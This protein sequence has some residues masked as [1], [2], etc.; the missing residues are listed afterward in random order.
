[1]PRINK[2]EKAKLES[3]ARRENS[4]LVS[5]EAGL[6]ADARHF[7]RLHPEAENN[8]IAMA[9]LDY[10]DRCVGDVDEVSEQANKDGYDD[11]ERDGYKDGEADVIK[12]YLLPVLEAAETAI[13]ARENESE[14]QAEVFQG[15]QLAIEAAMKFINK[16][17]N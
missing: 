7:L 2:I 5:I 8:A 10:M 16:K 17:G 11:G 4:K 9:V 14:D 3:L 15:L 1:M 13:S 12:E 6:S